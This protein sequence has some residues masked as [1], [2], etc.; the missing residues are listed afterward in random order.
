M[1][2]LAD[3]VERAMA[4]PN[5]RVGVALGHLRR[6]G[7]PNWRAERRAERNAALRLLAEMSIPCL[8]VRQRAQALIAKIDRYLVNA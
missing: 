1:V 2:E 8:S 6:G 7:E 5:R 4:T 3:L